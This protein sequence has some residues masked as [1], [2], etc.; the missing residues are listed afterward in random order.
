LDEAWK[1]ILFGDSVVV[2]PDEP[3]E[4]H[5]WTWKAKITQFFI[6]EFYDDRRVFSQGKYYNTATSASLSSVALQHS[7][8]SMVVLQP[9]P[10]Q[11]LGND[12]KLAHLLMHKF[13]PTPLVG[14][15]NGILLD[16]ELEDVSPRDHLFQLGMPGCCPPYPEVGDVVIVRNSSDRSFSMAVVRSVSTPTF[17]SDS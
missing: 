2:E 8:T 17:T 16:Y 11:W 3:Y 6:R 4:G 13:I 15:N 12:I 1:G 10:Q 14:Q 7:C 5:M 9:H